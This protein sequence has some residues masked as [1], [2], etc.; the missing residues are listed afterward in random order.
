VFD[1]ILNREPKAPIELNA[2]VPYSLE[3]VIAKC[4]QKDRG[5]RYQTAAEVRADLEQVRRERESGVTAS[6]PAAPIAAVSG[7]AW[8]SG[9]V[10]AAAAPSAGRGPLGR[11]GSMA[12]AAVGVLALGAAVLV[13]RRAEQPQSPVIDAA[14]SPE[15]APAAPASAPNVTVPPEGGAAVPTPPAPEAAPPTA[16]AGRSPV[17]T[18]PAAAARGTASANAGNRPAAARGGA[19]APAAAAAAVVAPVPAVDPAA[20]AIRI[21]RAKF[22]ARL[23]DQAYADLQGVVSQFA[24]NASVANAY[25]LMGNIRERQNRADDAMAAYVELRTKH[26]SS[27]AAAEGTFLNAELLLRSRR[28]DRERAAL[29]L[30]S[31]VESEHPA[32]P[33]APRA[34][35]RRAA[36]EDRLRLRVVDGQ[37]GASVPA[38]LVSYRSLV[39]RYPGAPGAEA[40]VDALAKLYQDLRRY[41]L[42]AGSLHELATRFP[43]NRVNAAWRAGELYEDRVKDMG[44]ARASY[45]LVPPGSDRYR[46][47]QRKLQP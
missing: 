41:D 28:N 21:A 18:A 11:Y 30:F 14:L 6:R 46:D 33:F 2:N 19:G 8:P 4:L 3:R 35:T 16:A 34:L 39:E 37:L 47:A 15:A 42:A 24:G 10:P 7:S 38:A 5:A 44:R 1:A 29:A 17:S 32:S 13:M 12:M 26:P 27:E 45:A 43:G 9:A 20:E 40:A 22:D 23:Y 31:A 36:L 25:L